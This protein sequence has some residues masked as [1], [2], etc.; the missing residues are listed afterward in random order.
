MDALKTISDASM[1]QEV[2]QFAVG[3]TVKVYV[4]IKE[5]DKSRIQL[6]E[7]TVIAKKHGGISET[8]TV[9][10][11]HTAAVSSVYSRCTLRL[12]TV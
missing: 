5:G 6:F 7:G 12:L 11:L 4:K 9:R 8:F 10:L 1:K 2:P 3:D